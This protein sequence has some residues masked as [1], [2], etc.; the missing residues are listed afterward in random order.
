V[1][2]HTLCTQNFAKRTTGS[3][4]GP[5]KNIVVKCNSIFRKFKL[6]IGQPFQP[7]LLGQL[8]VS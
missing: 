1:I 8:G 4:A 2:I 5:R 7:L 3:G 6:F